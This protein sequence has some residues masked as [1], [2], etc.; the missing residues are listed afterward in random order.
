M[1]PFILYTF[2]E[3]VDKNILLIDQLT[4]HFSIGSRRMFFFYPVLRPFRF[5]LRHLGEFQ[6]PAWKPLT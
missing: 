4:N 1:L 3:T 2:N 6:P 5:I